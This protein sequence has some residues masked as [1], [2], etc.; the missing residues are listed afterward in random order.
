[1]REEFYLIQSGPGYL[2]E[3]MTG[4]MVADT[5]DPISAALRAKRMCFDDAERVAGEMEAMGMEVEIIRLVCGKMDRPKLDQEAW[6]KLSGALAVEAIVHDLAEIF[7]PVHEGRPRA[8]RQQE[9][10][11]QE[12]LRVEFRMGQALIALE[13]LGYTVSKV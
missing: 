5:G 1:M 13:E 4:Q 9:V 8:L 2:A 3:P 12:Y 10:R 6:K 11:T 7:V